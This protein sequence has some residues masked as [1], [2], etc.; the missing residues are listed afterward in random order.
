MQ[1]TVSLIV[2]NEVQTWR[3]WILT[4]NA[5][6]GSRAL[7]VGASMPRLRLQRIIDVVLRRRMITT[8]VVGVLFVV[9][10]RTRVLRGLHPIEICSC[11]GGADR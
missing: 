6:V 4:S 10:V 2:M 1:V 3:T 7:V 5:I 9:R 11:G 8:V